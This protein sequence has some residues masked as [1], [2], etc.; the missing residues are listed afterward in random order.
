MRPVSGCRGAYS[1]LVYSCLPSERVPQQVLPS[2][3][4]DLLLSLFP[5]FQSYLVQ[6]QASSH[7]HISSYRKENYDQES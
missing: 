4:C 1:D 2:A 5:V 6:Q 7:V 3:R